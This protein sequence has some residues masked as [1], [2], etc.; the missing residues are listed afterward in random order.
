MKEEI[1]SI[2]RNMSQDEI[3][4]EMDYL[5]K[6]SWKSPPQTEHICFSAM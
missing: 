5:G 4:K 6:S 3:A 1:R 2:E